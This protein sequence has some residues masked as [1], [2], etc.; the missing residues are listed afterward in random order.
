MKLDGTTTNIRLT[1]ILGNQ[2]VKILRIVIWSNKRLNGVYKLI[3][4]NNYISGT[5][6]NVYGLVYNLNMTFYSPNRI[7]IESATNDRKRFFYTI[8]YRPYNF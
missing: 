2:S 1:S 5:A 8:Y 3:I 4:S 6:S 7:F